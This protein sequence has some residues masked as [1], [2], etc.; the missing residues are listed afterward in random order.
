MLEAHIVKARPAFVVDVTIRLDRGER[1]GLFG[2]SGAG[3][4]TVLS[5]LA[6]LETPDGGEIRC[7][8]ALLFPPNAPL[9]RRAIG[10]L[11]QSDSLFPHLTVGENV[12]FGLRNHE[13][14]GRFAMA[15]R[16]E[17][18]ARPWTDMEPAREAHFGR[19]GAARG[20]GADAGAAAAAGA[21]R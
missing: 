17:E 9:Y 4:S 7:D 18:S 21:A 3:K 15:R 5:C 1:L 8:G 13:R 10:Y 6:G 2:A 20:A 11:T 14:D 12:S 19:P 16:T